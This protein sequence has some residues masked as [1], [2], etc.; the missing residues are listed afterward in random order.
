M[1]THFHV[2]AFNMNN[3]YVSKKYNGMIRY[4]LCKA[5]VDNKL[6]S[7]ENIQFK[8][9]KSG[10]SVFQRPEF[11]ARS[12]THQRDY[13]VDNYTCA[14]PTNKHGIRLRGPLLTGTPLKV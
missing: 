12:S 5:L 7:L 10:L 13:R 2:L 3:C 14:L 11:D 6:W 1:V 8:S 9:F 4:S